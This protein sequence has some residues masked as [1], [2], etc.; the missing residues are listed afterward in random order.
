MTVKIKEKTNP[1]APAAWLLRAAKENKAVAVGII[2][3]GSNTVYPKEGVSVGE[4]AEKN[5]YGLGVPERPFIRGYCDK[6]EKQ[7]LE[8]IRYSAKV[9]MNTKQTL[10]WSLE[11][12]GKFAQNGIVN[13]I[14]SKGEGTYAPNAPQTIKRKGSDTPLVDTHLMKDMIDYEVRKRK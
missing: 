6:Y 14:L 12:V 9:A 11:Q 4:V 8:D 1:D 7:I 13:F 5:E 10:A 2:G 3:E